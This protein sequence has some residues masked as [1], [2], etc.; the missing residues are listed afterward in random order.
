MAQYLDMSPQ[1]FSN[2]MAGGRN[3]SDKTLVVIQ[4]AL[5]LPDGWY[6]LD[7]EG[8]G[9]LPAKLPMPQFTALNTKQQYTMGGETVEIF[10]LHN[11]SVMQAKQIDIVGIV[12]RVNTNTQPKRKKATT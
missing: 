5:K 3:F 12:V 1:Q 8:I 11:M 9:T 10:T 6:M 7:A 4:R 2:Y